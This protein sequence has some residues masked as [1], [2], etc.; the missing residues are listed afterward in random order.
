MEQK[1]PIDPDDVIIDISYLKAHG[2]VELTNGFVDH[3]PLLPDAG[4]SRDALREMKALSRRREC[5][6]LK[7]RR[8]PS[9]D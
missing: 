8:E 4:L 6:V 9:N 3:Y 7:S 5:E 1:P 2:W